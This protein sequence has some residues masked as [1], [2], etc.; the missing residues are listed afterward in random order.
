L[1]P[2]PPPNATLYFRAKYLIHTPLMAKTCMAEENPEVAI[3]RFD[4][5]AR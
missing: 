3:A 1:S 2:L 5:A 4:W